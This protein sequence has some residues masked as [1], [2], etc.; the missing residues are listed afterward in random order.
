MNRNVFIYIASS[1]VH[2]VASIYDYRR[3]Y[4]GGRRGGDNCRL[5]V[6]K[7]TG[8][9]P[10]P[11]ACKSSSYALYDKPALNEFELVECYNEHCVFI[12]FFGMLWYFLR[13]SNVCLPGCIYSLYPGGK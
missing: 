3:T 2:R 5:Q 4:P 1:N 10:M 6:E 11:R 8:I 13:F 9:K 12:A 7:V